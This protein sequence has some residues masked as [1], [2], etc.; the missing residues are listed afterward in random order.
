MINRCRWGRFYI[1]SDGLPKKVETVQPSKGLQQASHILR[2]RRS[3]FEALPA[4]WVPEAETPGVEW[5]PGDVPIIRMVEKITRE[6]MP[7]VLHMHTDLMRAAGFKFQAQET[8]VFFFVIR[9]QQAV[10]DGVVPLRVVDATLDDGILFPPDRCV[11][12]EVQAEDRIRRIAQCRDVREG[13]RKAAIEI[14]QAGMCIGGIC[15]TAQIES[16]GNH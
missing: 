9:K 6:R 16:G 4:D 10:R 7:E 12:G 13:V 14:L 1:P 8:Q 15:R 3:Q 11:D 2:E 5:L